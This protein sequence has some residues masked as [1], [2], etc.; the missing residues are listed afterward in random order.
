MPLAFTEP[1]L[2]RATACTE[3]VCQLQHY[4]QL[5]AA[6]ITLQT[7]CSRTVSI[8]GLPR[9]HSDGVAYQNVKEPRHIIAK[10]C[11]VGLHAECFEL[12]HGR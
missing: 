4:S 10:K 5:V 6:Y 1:L 7:I 3:R 12:H 11:N 2:M 9:A 8:T